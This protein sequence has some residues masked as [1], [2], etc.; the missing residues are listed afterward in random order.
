MLLA[1]KLEQALTKQDILT[2]YLN[3]VPFGKHAYGIQAAAQTYYGKPVSALSLAQM[4][5]LAGIPK[6]PEA[7][8]P[9]N[10]PKRALARRNLILDRMVEQGSITQTQLTKSAKRA[11]HGKSL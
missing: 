8:N 5:M 11:D 1:I 6:A 3:I 7:G 2:L 9:I 10:G 4:A